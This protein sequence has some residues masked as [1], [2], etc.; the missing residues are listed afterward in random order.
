M[1]KVSLLLILCLYWVVGCGSPSGPEVISGEQTVPPTTVPPTTVPSVAPPIDLAEP[2]CESLPQ[3]G[4]DGNSKYFAEVLDDGWYPVVIGDY[5]KGVELSVRCQAGNPSQTGVAYVANQPEMFS[6]KLC[7]GAYGELDDVGMEGL[8]NNPSFGSEPC[9]RAPSSM[10]VVLVEGGNFTRYLE[11]LR[12]YNETGNAEF[13]PN[14]S[15]GGSPPDT[16]A[17]FPSWPRDFG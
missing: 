5:P 12:P 11:D 16:Y 6:E 4:G 14:F 15:S 8:A 1:K 3:T 17:W 13:S 9:D 10:G 7:V 2:A